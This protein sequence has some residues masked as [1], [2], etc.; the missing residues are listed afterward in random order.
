MNVKHFLQ[1]QENKFWDKQLMELE[2]F[3]KKTLT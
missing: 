3:E 2:M 1:P